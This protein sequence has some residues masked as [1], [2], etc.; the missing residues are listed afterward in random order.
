MSS[1]SR[2]TSNPLNMRQLEVGGPY[3]LPSIQCTPILSDFLKRGNRILGFYFAVTIY[4]G[5]GKKNMDQAEKEGK[6]KPDTP[7]KIR[8][9]TQGI[10]IR[11][12]Y[13]LLKKTFSKAGAQLTNQ[14][15]LGIYGN[16]EAYMLDTISAALKELAFPSPD[17]E[18]VKTMLGTAWRGKFDRVVQKTGVTLGQRKMVDKFRNLDMGFLGEKCEDPIDFLNR[19]ADFRHRL[20]HSSGRVDMALI[21]KYPKVNLV[22]GDLMELPFGLPQG[23]HMFLVLLAEVVD[24]AFATRFNWTRSLVA[25]EQ[26]TD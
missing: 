11:Q 1:D 24:E 12:N 20:V 16:F 25:P 8:I 5:E 2:Q 4:A 13:G 9:E 17:D 3:V 15:F 14:V 7:T 26:L 10:D 18:A 19:M 23:I 6:L 22:D 21:K